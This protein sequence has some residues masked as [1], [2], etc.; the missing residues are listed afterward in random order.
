MADIRKSYA[1]KTGVAVE[2]GSDWLKIVQAEPGR[3]GVGVSKI[4]LEPFDPAASTSTLAQMLANA[5]RRERFAKVPVT[6]I[7][8]RQMVN[9]RMLELPSTDFDEIHDMVDLQIGKQTPYSR[10]EIVSGY[11]LVRSVREGYSRVL[12]AIIQRTTLRQRYHVFEE[13]GVEVD[14]MTVS[15]EGVVN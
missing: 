6:A 15:T 2:I 12:L 9:V 13:A 8:P 11:R 5:L 7:L 1:R 4:T 14:R 3:R 10:D